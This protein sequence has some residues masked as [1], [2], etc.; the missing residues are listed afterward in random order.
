MLYP[1][2][3]HGVRAACA[4]SALC[5]GTVF[6]QPTL[7]TLSTVP[8]TVNEAKV[9][10]L[11]Y[12]LTPERRALLATIRYA[13]GTWANGDPVG[14][15]IMFGGGTFNDL[16][17]HPDQVVRGWRYSS[18]AAGAYQFMP[19]T[20]AN[21]AA[22]LKL[23]SFGPQ[24]QDQ[25]ALWLVQKRGALAE[26]DRG[27]FSPSAVNRLSPEWAS[28]PT[29]GGG[30]YYGQP[31]KGYRDLHRF[32]HERLKEYQQPVQPAVAKGGTKP[33][34]KRGPLFNSYFSLDNLKPRIPFA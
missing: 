34:P 10:T 15:R 19:F 30:S 31:V 7:A 32:F 12:E 22:A 9:E 1:I 24:D 18:A 25:A 28:F 6:A 5:A 11:K 27:Q 29:I 33:Q 16:S 20:W 13:E 3:T 8:T 14:Y 2:L 23:N 26:I 17:R 21:A 4:A